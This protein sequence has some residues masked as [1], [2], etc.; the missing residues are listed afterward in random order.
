[1]QAMYHERRAVFDAF[2]SLSMHMAAQGQKADMAVVGQ[3][4]RHVHAAGFC[5]DKELAQ[6]LVD[7]FNA[8]FAVADFAR[9]HEGMP[10]PPEDIA[11]KLA[12]VYRT[13]DSLLEE[14]K[15]AVPA[16]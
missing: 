6:K 3:F 13:S 11:A 10:K 15:K 8:A 9:A 12:Q 1:M 16:Q 14:L 7:Y 2:L 4:Y 5:F